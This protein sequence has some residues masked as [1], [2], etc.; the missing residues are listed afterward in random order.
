M[1]S[2]PHL[3]K[4]VVCLGGGTGASM[5]IR[6]LE[7]QSDLSAVVSMFDNGGSTGYLRRELD[8][9][10]VGDLRQC[11]IALTQKKEL[12]ALLKHRF[13]KGF[14]RGHNS[15]NILFAAAI[16]ERGFEKGLKCLER[17]FEI[18]G[19]I[20]PVSLDNS[21][22]MAILENGKTIKGEEE[23][24]N[25][26]DISKIGLK[27]LYLSPAAKANPKALA[28]IKKAD[29]VIIGPGKFYTSLVSNLLVEGI[30]EGLERSKAKKILVCN[31]MT[32]PGNTD[33]FTVEKFLSETEKYIGQGVVDHIVFNT[34][35]LSPQM[36][37][38]VKKIFVGAEF[39]GYDKAILKDKKFVGA[40]LL[41]LELK[42]LN[43]S[44]ILIKGVNQRTMVGHDPKKL[45]RVLSKIINR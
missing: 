13:G 2:K 32:Q 35:K 6:A 41:G 18:S 37:K 33:G 10:P 1:H 40:D 24:V 25:C 42:P 44:D 16:E 19:K 7:G 31:I 9:P 43:P 11:L 8:L 14:L 12:A 39:V 23:I 29:F 30:A 17:I 36:S 15:G 38:Q 5:V 21:S 3:K 45:A 22:L 20:I 4:K 27:K 28:E 26:R 34:K